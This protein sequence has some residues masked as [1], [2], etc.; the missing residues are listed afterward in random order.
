MPDLST[1]VSCPAARVSASWMDFSEADESAGG[2]PERAMAALRDVV[3]KG[4]TPAVIDMYERACW[5]VGI[6]PDDTA[7]A[8]LVMRS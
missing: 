6:S 8:I 4:E 1:P 2:N 5:R 3:R 7:L